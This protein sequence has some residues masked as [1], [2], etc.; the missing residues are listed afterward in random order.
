MFLRIF[1][2]VLL[3]QIQWVS[4]SFSHI[5]QAIRQREIISKGV[6]LGGWLV[7]ERWMTETSPVWKGVP[8]S[9]GDQGEYAVMKFLGL[10]EGSK[11]M[12]QHRATWITERDIE[13]I[14]SF[15]INTVRVPIGYWI[16]G[17]DNDVYA[18]G[19][20][21]YLDLLIKEW[22]NK[23]NIAVLLSLHAHKGSQNG[24]DHS[25]PHTFGSKQWSSNLKNVENSIHWATFLAE[26]YKNTPAFLG[27]TLM[28][29]PE[30]PTDLSI[31]KNYYQRTH[32]LI[33]ASGNDC[34]L[35]MSPLL[36]EQSPLYMHTFMQGVPN[37]WL[38]WHPYFVWGFEGQNE[39]QILAAV[40]GYAA[41]IRAWNGNPLYLSEWS[42]GSPPSALFANRDVFRRFGQ[43]QLNGLQHA[44][45][46]W[47]FWAWKH[48]DDLQGKRTGWSM[49]QLLRNGDL[50]I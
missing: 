34:I 21:K 10:E 46:G 20:L 5:Q 47:A 40:I 24:R 23:Y 39:N 6:N 35:V 36:S 29:E 42:L 17:E 37:V 15:G 38:E 25:A 30:A 16:T 8:L 31:V 48:S 49:R 26:R 1:V 41:R 32:D 13:E 11:R 9:I 18:P 3:L 4:S 12:E 44:R 43:L 27:M 33:R 2:A 28:N 45:A 7:I 50:R 14:A 22:A 19:A